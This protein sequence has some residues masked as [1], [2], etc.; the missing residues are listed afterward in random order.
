MT[1]DSGEGE[2]V[3]WQLGRRALGEGRVEGRPWPESSDCKVGA[4]A[5]TPR[6][7]VGGLG[8]HTPPPRFRARGLMPTHLLLFK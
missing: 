8:G 1:S 4:Q 3:V 2:Q 6:T 5:G 7:E